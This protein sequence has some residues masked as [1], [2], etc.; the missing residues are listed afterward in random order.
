LNLVVLNQTKTF[1]ENWIISGVGQK[2]LCTNMYLVFPGDLSR[3][4][5]RPIKRGA[6]FSQINLWFAAI[7]VA[8]CVIV[9]ALVIFGLLFSQEL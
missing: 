6:D 4:Y 8:C 5:L 1:N 7:L 3:K 9:F 2:I